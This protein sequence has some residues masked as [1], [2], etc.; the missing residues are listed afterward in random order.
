M[1]YKPQKLQLSLT[2][3]FAVFFILITV[4]IYGYFS[5]KFE[6]E[7]LE[8]E[9]HPAFEGKRFVVNGLFQNYSREALK[10]EIEQLGGTLVSGVTAKTDYVIAGEGMGPSKK[11]QAESLGLTVLRE[12]AYEKLKS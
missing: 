9:Y 3:Q 7:V 11:E 12:E 1:I 8:H 10:N 4:F 5:Q 2:I 6:E